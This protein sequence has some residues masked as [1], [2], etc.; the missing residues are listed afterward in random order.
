[1]TLGTIVGIVVAIVATICLILNDLPCDIDK[2]VC[3]III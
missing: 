1:M 3:H 2:V